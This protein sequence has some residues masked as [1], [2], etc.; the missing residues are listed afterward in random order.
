MQNA[1]NASLARDLPATLQYG[2]DKCPACA[3]IEKL[4]SL[5][6][7]VTV[8]APGSPRSVVVPSR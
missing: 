2:Y 8:Y 4:R 1:V 5:P 6:Q 7:G 3:E